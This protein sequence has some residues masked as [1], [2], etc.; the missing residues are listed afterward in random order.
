MIAMTPPAIPIQ[1]PSDLL[2]RRPDIAQAERQMASANAA[3]GVAIAAYFPTFT[4][5]GSQGFENNQI[6]HWLFTEPTLFWSIGPQLAETILDG[7]LRQAQVAAAR[8]AYQQTVANYRQT[9][10]AAVQ[11]V[12]DNLAAL[13]IL[14]SEAVVQK[15]AVDAAVISLNLQIASYQNGTV[16]YNN[17][18]SAENTANTA[19]K[20]NADVGGRRMVAAVG[21]ITALGGGWQGL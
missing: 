9:V 4:L 13:R 2:E 16:A 7:G 3:I 10:L 20:N 19:K 5:S 15:Q 1:I 11:N 8:A 18:I 21:L 12:E 6:Q 17:V 14:K